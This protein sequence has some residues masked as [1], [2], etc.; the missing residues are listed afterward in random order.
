MV[1]D[2]KKLNLKKENEQF[3]WD[4]KTDKNFSQ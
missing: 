1:I 3:D 2:S 4:E